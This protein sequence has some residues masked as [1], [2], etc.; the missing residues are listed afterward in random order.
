M[1]KRIFGHIEGFLQ[2]SLFN[3]RLELSRAGLHRPTQ[4][5]I[6]GSGKEGADSIVLSGGYE[7]DIDEGDVII[8]TG[9]G[10]NDPGTGT[11]IRHQ[12]LERG[13]LALSISKDQNLPVRVIRSLKHQS[14]ASN[15]TQYQY[16]GLYLVE[17]YWSEKGRSGFNIY[18]YRL[19]KIRQ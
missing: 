16:D 8:Y 9:H 12:V 19:V 10:G 17:D 14:S 2:G 18:R 11:Q 15:S 7:D 5:G 4:A 13:N 1:S 6:S 3:S